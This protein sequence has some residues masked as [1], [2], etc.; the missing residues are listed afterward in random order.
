MSNRRGHLQ[1]ALGRKQASTGEVDSASNTAHSVALL[2]MQIGTSSA[3]T[4][5]F[6][7]RPILPQMDARGDRLSLAWL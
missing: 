5:L 6:R 4:G 7:E 2:K 3:T 1:Q